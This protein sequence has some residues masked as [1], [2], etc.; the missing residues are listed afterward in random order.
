MRKRKDVFQ[1]LE[2]YLVRKGGIRQRAVEIG[3]GLI[4]A[5][6]VIVLMVVIFQ[7]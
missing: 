7:I 6:L 2:E 4:G 3:G 5:F 1:V